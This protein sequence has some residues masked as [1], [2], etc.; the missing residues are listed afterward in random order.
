MLFY[1][2]SVTVILMKIHIVSLLTR[3]ITEALQVENPERWNVTLHKIS[4]KFPINSLQMTYFGI[5]EVVLIAL[6]LCAKANKVFY[7]LLYFI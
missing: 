5:Y 2:S 4:L 1:G 3:R 7:P 6:S